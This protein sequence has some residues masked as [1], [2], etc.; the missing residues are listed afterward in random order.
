MKGGARMRHHGPLQRTCTVEGPVV[1]VG[2]VHLWGDGGME[3]GDAQIL[4]PPMAG[5][6][7]GEGEKGVVRWCPCSKIVQAHHVAIRGGIHKVSG[8]IQLD[9]GVLRLPHRVSTHGTE[10]LVN[11]G[12]LRGQMQKLKRGELA[13]ELPPQS[14]GPGLPPKIGVAVGAA[15]SPMQR[16]PS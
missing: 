16:M 11:G 2:D 8:G 6:M 4:P 3:R 12:R 9:V 15:C 7:P 10:Q 1:G 14:C 13:V 5:K